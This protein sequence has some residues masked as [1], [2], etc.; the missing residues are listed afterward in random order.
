MSRTNG[1]SRN[2]LI[3]RSG[4]SRG[5]GTETASQH[6]QVVAN[7]AAIQEAG[8]PLPVHR[9]CDSRQVPSGIYRYGGEVC[10]EGRL[11][12]V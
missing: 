7:D 11:A 1:G 4:G 3:S 12:E 8:L 2:S 9:P 6:V 10:S 5:D